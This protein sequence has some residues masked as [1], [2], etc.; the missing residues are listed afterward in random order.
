MARA[1]NYEY[2]V[3]INCPFDAAYRPLFDALVF[4]THDCGYIARCALEVDDASE[5]RIEKIARIIAACRYGIHDVSRTEP[6]SSSGLP[7]F[8]MP[9][10][11][12]LFLGAKRFGRPEQ[13]QK[14]CLILDRELYRYQQ[15]ISDISGQDIHAHGGDPGEAI[16][17]VR[18]WLSDATRKGVRIP[19]GSMVAQRYRLFREQLPEACDRLHLTEQDLTFNNFVVLVE[20]WLKAHAEVAG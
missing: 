19:G 10:E 20:E 6:D 15:Y 13:R 11:L 4:A 12:G 17:I 16:R 18:N 5:V 9:L 8:N 2:N 3:F 14:S 1:A 7:R